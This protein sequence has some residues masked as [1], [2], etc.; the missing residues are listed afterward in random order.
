GDPT[1]QIK[2]ARLY[3]SG[4]QKE[5]LLSLPANN[6]F[7]LPAK[8]EFE[9]LDVSASKYVLEISDN[10]GFEGAEKHETASPSLT[11]S[12]RE[13]AEYFWRVISFFAEGEYESAAF[14]FDT[15]VPKKT[16]GAYHAKN[17]GLIEGDWRDWPGEAALK[18]ADI[19][20][21]NASLLQSL[22]DY[23]GETGGGE[24]ILPEGTY[25]LKGD[26]SQPS[27]YALY[28]RYDNITL[29]GAGRDENGGHK[30]VL[31]TPHEWDGQN[32]KFRNSAICIVGTPFGS[33]KPRENVRLE[34]FE[35]DGGR[36]WTGKYD[37]GY[38]PMVNY[39]WDIH[40]K[41]I[42]V[43]H[44]NNVSHAYLNDLFVHGFS[45][46]TVYVGGLSVG[47]LE[48]SNCVFADTNASCFNL[49]AS[50]L[51]V[52]GCDFG[53]M[54]MK[55]RFWIEFCNRASFIG[56]EML[57]IPGGLEKDTAYFRD[58]NFYG[59]VGATAIVFCQ[60]DLTNYAV[61][62]ENNTVDNKTGG[63]VGVFMFGGAVAG[64]I[65]ISGNRFKNVNGPLLEI[66]FGGGT[67]PENN[68]YNGNILFE[69]NICENVGGLT[70]LAGMG[71][72]FDQATQA[73]VPRTPVENLT[74]ANNRFV[75]RESHT[76]SISVGS[77]SYD[78]TSAVIELTGVTVT[79]NT[80]INCVTPEAF[81]AFHGKL[82]FF[83]GN[84]YVETTLSKNGGINEL[85]A[86]SPLIRPVYEYLTLK[87]S[88]ELTAV[89]RASV[90]HDGQ[91]VALTG[92]AGTAPIVFETGAQSY[93]VPEQ[94]VLSEGA[95]ICFVYE[96]K[97]EMWI[98]RDNP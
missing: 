83:A 62:F 94:I 15:S 86:A 20:S 42:T 84:E 37:W 73:Y 98:Y 9:W 23:A 49:Y 90:Y 31:R 52:Y 55:C 82:P 93:Y 71:S 70:F 39:G 48:V 81:D 96:A 58:N 50:T 29:R 64:P 24:I 56:Y 85:S 97:R 46:E 66:S 8:V 3:H 59:A 60:G 27:N 61:V 21:R 53:R 22:I 80:F 34:S 16:N 88:E 38:D 54:D 10:P 13:N 44:D 78:E 63:N 67:S 11:L 1:V 19:A 36:G 57:P 14:V 2:N 45:G 74:I 65:N 26:T 77:G 69:N 5:P 40:H 47:Y 25:C 43:A 87:A 72:V 95:E 51:N 41:G 76:K 75:G 32:L 68:L 89:M 6:S 33:S 4:P 12:L 30:T 18:Y 79:G 28:V 17:Y 92:A 91:T 7:F 35:L